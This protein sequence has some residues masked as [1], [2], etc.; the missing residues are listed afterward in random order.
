[1]ANTF[2]KMLATLASLCLT[3]WAFEAALE[4]DSECAESNDR[5]AL[6]ALQTRA[7][8]DEPTGDARWTLP[9]SGNE[10]MLGFAP[11][12]R[13]QGYQYM[14]TSSRYG[15]NHITGCMLDSRAVVAGTD[16]IAVAAASSMHSQGKLCWKNGGGNGAASMGCGSCAK[17]RFIR[18][19]PRG[20]QIWT[21]KSKPIFHK[22]Y[23][24]VVVDSCPSGDNALWCPAPGRT[25]TFGVHN[26]F[27]MAN[28]PPDFDNFYFQF[29]PTPCSG[30]IQARFKKLSKC[31]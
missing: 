6:N 12:P 31:R 3:A 2:R 23:K 26:H 18:K 11:P 20:Y 15:F 9:P 5:C 27:D 4:A 22:E 21:P 29:S 30:E 10:T 1:M 16:Y 17:G 8:T 25:N 7:R 28:P 14:A 24:V 19:L 13:P